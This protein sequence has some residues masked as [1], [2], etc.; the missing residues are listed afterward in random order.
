LINPDST[1]YN[2]DR[3]DNA[4]ATATITG[5][6]GANI[7]LLNIYAAYS[8]LFSGTLTI[9]EGSTT[10]MTLD[11]QG[12]LQLSDLTIQFSEGASV[13]AELSASG[14]AGVYGSVFLHG[15]MS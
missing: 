2:S 9:K 6:T 7:V 5:E 8:D 15:Y 4:V 1:Y 12:K 14:E 11:V 3:K 13:S 10:K